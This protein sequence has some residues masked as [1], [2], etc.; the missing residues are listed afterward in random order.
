V[1]TI[2]WTQC[3]ANTV[4]Y[5]INNYCLIL[6]EYLYC[7]SA[8]KHQATLVTVTL[9]PFQSL[10]YFQSVLLHISLRFNGHFP[11]E[12]GL[13]G[14]NRCSPGKWPLK[15]REI[16]YLFSVKLFQQRP[17]WTFL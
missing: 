14:V 4:L 11:G 9:N 1:I 15:W 2:F 6:Q 7:R 17:S 5:I 12:P 8:N 3:V 13:A 16:T 10:V